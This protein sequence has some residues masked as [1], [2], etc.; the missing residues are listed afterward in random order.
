MKRP[1]DVKRDAAG[2]ATVGNEGGNIVTMVKVGERLMLVAQRGVYAVQMADQIDPGR[3]DIHLPNVIQ[4]QVLQYGTEMP[5][6]ARTLATAKELFNA[7][8]LGTEF[9]QEHATSLAFEAAQEYATVQGVLDTLR[10]DQ[11]DAL[12]KLE[13]LPLT[14][15]IQLP[16]IRHLSGHAGSVVEHLRRAHLKLTTIANLFYP[17]A[18]PNDPWHLS[19]AAGLAGRFATDKQSEEFFAEIVRQIE[20][21]SNYRNAHIHPDGGKSLTVH[22]FELSPG[23]TISIP[24]IEIAHPKS[25]LG[26]MGIVTFVEHMID[27][28]S[29]AFDGLCAI[30]CD[31]NVKIFGPLVAQVVY[32]APEH[33]LNGVRFTWRA[34]F[35]EGAVLP[36]PRT[37][38]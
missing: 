24:S 29:G 26:R 31:A 17:K 33:E 37:P 25:A 27:A 7:A 30:L 15:A 21:V 18:R 35:K 14:A 12:Q 10:A 22:D 9:P 1:I 16:T 36:P 20:T 11:E 5:F 23:P 38:T 3:T 13:G 2:S 8:Y 28:C 4:Q 6:V 32:R 19:V 34:D